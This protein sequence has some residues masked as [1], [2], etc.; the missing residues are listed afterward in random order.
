MTLGEGHSHSLKIGNQLDII[1]AGH[2]LLAN[3]RKPKLIQT[4]ST[5]E[6]VVANISELLFSTPIA[7]S[8]R[9][10]WILDHGSKLTIH[11]PA[12]AA[13]AEY[14]AHHVPAFCGGIHQRGGNRY[15]KPKP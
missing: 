7:L 4:F 1:H 6:G 14:T 11:L 10:I 12:K 15:G 13:L 8:R 5:G 3:I 2:I 9:R